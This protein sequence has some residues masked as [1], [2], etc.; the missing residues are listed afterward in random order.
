MRLADIERKTAETAIAAVL[1]LDGA[2]TAAIQTGVGFFDHMLT[3]WTRHGLFDLTLEAKGDM[4][5][6]AHHTVEDVGIVLGQAFAAA[7]GDKQGIRRYGTAFVPMD[8]ALATV[9]LD[10]SGRPYLVYEVPLPAQK[11]GEFDTEL[12]EEFLRAFAVH[13]GVTLHVRL[14]AGKNTHHI[15]E[16]VFKA[17]GRA[18]DK[19]SRKDERIRGVLST[20]GIL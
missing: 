4:Q 3:L 10:I 15:L 7:L 5:V 2:G 6:D 8:E 19:A 11:V 9:S 18:L 17:L 13:A 14:L 20:K 12:A 1:N 16:A